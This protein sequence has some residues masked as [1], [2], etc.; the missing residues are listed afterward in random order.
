MLD[1]RELNHTDN[2][3]SAVAL[4]NFSGPHFIIPQSQNERSDGETYQLEDTL[5]S[6]G[7]PRTPSSTSRFGAE[8]Q[9]EKLEK[10]KGEIQEVG[11]LNDLLEWSLANACYL[12]GVPQREFS[13]TMLMNVSLAGLL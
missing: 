3:A 13:M 10:D 5:H 8:G 12:T 11:E 9:V 2:D 4:S 7:S 6:N 1:L